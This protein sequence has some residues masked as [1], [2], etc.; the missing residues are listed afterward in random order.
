MMNIFV[1][2]LAI[3]MTVMSCKN[4]N[5]SKS[6]KQTVEDNGKKIY[7][8]YCYA[9]HQTDGSGVPG[10]YPP[11]RNSE[12]VNGDKSRLVT[13]ITRG[14]TGEIE[15]NGIKY[16]NAMPRQNFLTDTEVADV[17][18]YIRSNFENS[19]SAVT[20]YDVEKARAENE[21]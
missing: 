19:A 2:L 10:M 21:Q 18:T 7:L 8:R 6:Y 16:N 4:S 13:I 11:I 20:I 12:V 5:N 3:F 15:V 9:C 1:Y 14:M 17:L